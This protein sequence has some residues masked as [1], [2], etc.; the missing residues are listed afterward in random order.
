[1]S[2]AKQKKTNQQAQ[3]N[4]Q[5][6]PVSV[7]PYRK[8]R[9]L[10]V[11]FIEGFSLI[12]IEIL[13]AK[14]INSY[15]GSSLKVWSIVLSMTLFFLA[16]GYFYGG[17]LSKDKIDQRLSNLFLIG[18]FSLLFTLMVSNPIFSSISESGFFFG[19][20]VSAI[21][22]LGP[23]LFLLGCISPLIIQ[24]ISTE[25]QEETGKVSGQVYFISTIGGI[26]GSFL[27]GTFLL[28]RLGITLL[29]LFIALVLL[30]VSF[31]I[32]KQS[33]SRML[34]FGGIYLFL[35]FISY[36]RIFKETEDAVVVVYNNEGIFG[37][38]KVVD[39]P[40]KGTDT[41]RSL[42][43]NG[44]NQTMIVNVP[45]AL[46]FWQYPHVVNSFSTLKG[47]NPK[48]LLLGLG[49]GSIAREL[50]THVTD[51]DVVEIDP[52]I[53]E[54]SKNY[55]YLN[56]QGMNFYRDDA[57]HYVKQCKKKYDMVVYDVLTGETQPNYVFTQEAL[58]ELDQILQPDAIVIVNY[59]GIASGPGDEAFRTLYKTFT[60]AG[61]HVNL[62]HQ[63]RKNFGDIVFV[64]SKKKLDFSKIRFENLNECCQHAKSMQ[65]V[66][67]HPISEFVPDTRGVA[68]LTDD[69]PNLELLNHEAIFKWRQSMRKINSNTLLSSGLS[70]FY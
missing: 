30:S 33:Q 18:A 48:T 42:S 53:I 63:F 20:I 58:K 45:Q 1:M 60:S 68:L 64:M 43:I 16:I 39:R 14:I 56:H 12:F 67:K 35:A 66:N 55:F 32:R 51:L 28:E 19:L 41:Y 54:V 7:Y 62:K 37:Q 4:N 5:S 25:G 24:K 47:K 44:V 57:R 9:Y 65:D 31:Y 59:Q 21:F 13:G 34:I 26:L 70:L 61:F 2:K 23:G 29:L 3:T 17:K 36:N 50:K 69:K 46:S 27:L 11:A 15:F 22:L 38:I 10:Q 6:K 52:R 49:G 40:L 8:S